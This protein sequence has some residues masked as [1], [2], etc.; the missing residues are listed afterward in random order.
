M[1]SNGG[2]EK[3]RDVVED[4]DNLGLSSDLKFLKQ[5]HGIKSLRPGSVTLILRLIVKPTESGWLSCQMA[6]Y[7]RV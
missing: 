6:K 1:T 5:G 3:E 2:S 4:C 7:F